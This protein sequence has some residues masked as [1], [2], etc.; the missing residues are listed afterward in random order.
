MRPVPITKSRISLCLEGGGGI[1]QASEKVR[2]I[3]AGGLIRNC[4]D[5]ACAHHK[6]QNLTVSGERGESAAAKGCAGG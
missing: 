5:K 3:E 4:W 2:E 6:V 1:L